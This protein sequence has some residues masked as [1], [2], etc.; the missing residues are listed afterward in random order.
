MKPRVTQKLLKDLFEEGRYYF[1]KGGKIMRKADKTYVK[2][3]MPTS[4]HK[5]SRAD[6]FC[7][8][9]NLYS[10]KHGVVTV[11]MTA[12]LKYGTEHNLLLNEWDIV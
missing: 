8:Q 5:W 12:L 10:T 11:R 1:F 7:A 6:R 4:K 2:M 9:Y 3:I